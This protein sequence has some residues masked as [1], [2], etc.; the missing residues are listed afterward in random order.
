ME[1]PRSP[2]PVKYAGKSFTVSLRTA[3]DGYAPG[4]VVAGVRTMA[5]GFA[6]AGDILNDEMAANQFFR[7]VTVEGSAGQVEI[8]GKPAPLPFASWLDLDIEVLEEIAADFFRFASE[9]MNC[10]K[11]SDSSTGMMR[12]LTLISGMKKQSRLHTSPQAKDRWNMPKPSSDSA[13]SRS[14]STT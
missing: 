14:Q 7:L 4:W 9:R 5:K 2:Y 13:G 3:P 12:A 11:N 1:S 8:D 6:V 10:S